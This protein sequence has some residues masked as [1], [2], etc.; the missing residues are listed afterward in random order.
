MNNT[1]TILGREIKYSELNLDDN[2][3]ID[4]S[5]V[6][7]AILESIG[8]SINKTYFCGFPDLTDEEFNSMLELHLGEIERTDLTSSNGSKFLRY[9]GMGLLM[10]PNGIYFYMDHTGLVLNDPN[11]PKE[12]DIHVP[13]SLDQFISIMIEL[14]HHESDILQDITRICK[15]RTSIKKDIKKM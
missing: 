11:L 1:I 8:K 10:Y 2:D 15:I 3:Y 4:F 6:C 9:N 13:I 12:K 5:R 7:I 14:K